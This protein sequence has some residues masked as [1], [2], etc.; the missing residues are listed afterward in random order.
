MS[1]YEFSLNCIFLFEDRIYESVLK[2]E[3]KMSAK[4]PFFGVF[5][6]YNYF[7]FSFFFFQNK[8]TALDHI[9][10]RNTTE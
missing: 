1:E 2:R 6:Y 4:N 9:H 7:L 8:H 10:N 3:N 5:L